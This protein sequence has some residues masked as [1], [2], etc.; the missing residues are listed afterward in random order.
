MNCSTC[1]QEMAALGYCDGGTVYHCERC[2]TVS[3]TQTLIGG[4]PRVYVPKLVKR[5]R[6]F[7][8][9]ISSP[10]LTARGVAPEWARLG[11][12][13]AIHLAEDRP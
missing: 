11:I 10:G 1:G 5:C 12:A 2:G 7:E 8:R 4:E 9:A 3:H 13:E 6:D